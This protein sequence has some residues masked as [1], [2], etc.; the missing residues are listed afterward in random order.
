MH[1]RAFL[2]NLG[3]AYGKLRQDKRNLTM[4]KYMRYNRLQDL[5]LELA[6]ALAV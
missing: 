6:H 2:T 4:T 5:L 1:E 3:N